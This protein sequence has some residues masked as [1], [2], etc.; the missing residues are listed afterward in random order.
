MT[1]R[2]GV[3]Q[4]AF[5]SEVTAGQWVYAFTQGTD[6]AT[7]APTENGLV[8]WDNSITRVCPRVNL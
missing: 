2:N 8:H 6:G 3:F 4:L 7:W 5:S 1:Y